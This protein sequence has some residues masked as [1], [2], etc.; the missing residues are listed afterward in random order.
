MY[1]LVVVRRGVLCCTRQRLSFKLINISWLE[2]TVLGR[3][4]DNESDDN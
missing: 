2:R 3:S 1:L 4:S